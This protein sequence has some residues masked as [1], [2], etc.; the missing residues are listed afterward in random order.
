MQTHIFRSSNSEVNIN[1]TAA[2]YLQ[3]AAD[4]GHVGA[5]YSIGYYYKQCKGAK[6][7]YETAAKYYQLA[8]EQGHTKAQVAI[9]FLYGEGQGVKQEYDT[10]FKYFQLQLQIRQTW[11]PIQSRKGVVS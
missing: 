7:D 8:A 1:Q 2:K 3:L 10:A 6:R 5:Q 4:Q 11:D 9:G